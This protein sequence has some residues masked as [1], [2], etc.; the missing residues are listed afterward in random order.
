MCI[1]CNLTLSNEAL[2]PNKLSRHLETNHESLKDKPKTYIENLALQKDKE[3]KRFNKYMK[4]PERGLVASC[5]V[6]YLLAKRKKAHT[7]AESVI[8]PSV[9]I[10]VE[11][12]LGSDAA[13]A[14]SKVP[15]SNDTIS[16]KIEDLPSDINDQIR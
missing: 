12:M 7:D 14:V 3:A 1:I 8:A 5:K 6:A 2:V 10:I 4:F 13:D 11:T 16:R 9:S 15:L